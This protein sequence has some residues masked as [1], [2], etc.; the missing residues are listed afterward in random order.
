MSAMPDEPPPKK[1]PVCVFNR[2]PVSHRTYLNPRRFIPAD[3]NIVSP[4]TNLQGTT[5]KS[6]TDHRSFGAFGKTHIRQ[7]F[8]NLFSQRYLYHGKGSSVWGIRQ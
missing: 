1:Q 2:G 7:A 4:D 3:Q 6:G 8:T 5:E